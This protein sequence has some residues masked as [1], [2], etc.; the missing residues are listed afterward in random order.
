VAG[1]IHEYCKSGGWFTG[2]VQQAVAVTVLMTDA[3][4][5]NSRAADAALHTQVLVTV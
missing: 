5:S 3:D 4:S 1:I 2:D